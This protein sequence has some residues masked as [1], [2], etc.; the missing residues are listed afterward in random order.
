MVMGVGGFLGFVGSIGEF[1]DKSFLVRY[2]EC[3]TNMLLFDQH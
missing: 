2:S 1:G 3:V